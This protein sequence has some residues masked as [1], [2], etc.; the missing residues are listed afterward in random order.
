MK[1]LDGKE[2]AWWDETVDKI[3][4]DENILAEALTPREEFIIRKRLG[5]YRDK[6]MTLAAIGKE[7]GVTQERIRQIESK[8]IRKV[9]KFLDNT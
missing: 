3:R 7:V 4:D 9:K 6:P 2:I 1:I 5:L 8:G